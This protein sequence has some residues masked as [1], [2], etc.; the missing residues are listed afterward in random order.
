MIANLLA[1]AAARE[2]VADSPAAPVL[3]AAATTA[4]A[5]EIATLAGQAIQAE[6]ARQRALEDCNHLVEVVRGLLRA[7]GFR[8]TWRD[9]EH[10]VWVLD[11]IEVERPDADGS[12]LP[13]LGA[14]RDALA[15]AAAR[16]ARIQPR[17]AARRLAVRR[18]IRMLRQVEVS[19]APR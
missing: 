13:W 5:A 15:A 1:T 17:N 7:A 16:G 9:G 11:E 6:T 14:A 19:H 8:E 3:E 4:L 10:R 12:L 2:A 18:A